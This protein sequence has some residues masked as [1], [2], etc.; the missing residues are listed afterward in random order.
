MTL[1]VDVSCKPRS[2]RRQFARGLRHPQTQVQSSSPNSYQ[3]V[4]VAAG[5]AVCFPKIPWFLHL[6]ETESEHWHC[7]HHEE[8]ER[9]ERKEGS[10]A[11]TVADR[12]EVT[13]VVD[14]MQA[15]IE[16][17]RVA[18]AFETEAAEIREAAEEEA[19]AVE[20]EEEEAEGE[21]EV[22]VAVEMTIVRDYLLLPETGIAQKSQR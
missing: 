11:V 20:E 5:A 6:E 21:E 17:D 1:K 18:V 9:K 7:D 13:K 8:A 10:M 3:S 19:E 2:P 14:W 12:V 15:T 22:A 4:V 16:V